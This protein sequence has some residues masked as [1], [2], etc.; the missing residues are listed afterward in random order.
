MSRDLTHVA[1]AV[2]LL[3]ATLAQVHLQGMQQMA[4][5][6][7]S[8]CHMPPLYVHQHQ[9]WPYRFTLE[10]SGLVTHTHTHTPL[11]TH[12]FPSSST[13][14]RMQAMQGRLLCMPG[15]FTS[16]SR[17]SSGLVPALPF[18]NERGSRGSLPGEGGQGGGQGEGEM[19][20]SQSVPQG[21][22]MLPPISQGG[23]VRERGKGERRGGGEELEGGR[24]W[25]CMQTI[26]RPLLIAPFICAESFHQCLHEASRLGLHLQQ[27]QQ[28]WPAE[29]RSCSCA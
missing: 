11:H 21:A 2:D 5:M 16:T 26:S 8:L 19:R 12:T 10:A 28:Q 23:Q 17:N 7:A 18:P 9:S 22:Q 27:Q 15:L 29:R 14:N 20:R 1:Q 4:M 6:Q 13:C 24:E 25:V 3:S